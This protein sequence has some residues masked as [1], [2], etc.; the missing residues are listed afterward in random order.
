MTLEADYRKKCR[1]ELLKQL[2]PSDIVM[3]MQAQA[4]RAKAGDTKAARLVLAYQLGEPEKTLNI[5]GPIKL[6]NISKEA[7][8]AV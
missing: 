2:S 7:E 3:I 5:N 8:D 4:E 6:Y 1:E